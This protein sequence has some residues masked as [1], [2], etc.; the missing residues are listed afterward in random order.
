M[1][2]AILEKAVGD[3]DAMAASAGT[4]R[5]ASRELIVASLERIDG[6]L[7]TAARESLSPDVLDDLRRQAVEDLGPFR[8]RMATDAWTRARDAAVRRAI[9]ER[10]GLPI[11]KAD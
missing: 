10:V 9:R 11:M 4:A 1:P 2:E 5:G 8:D 3:I 6:E 7:M